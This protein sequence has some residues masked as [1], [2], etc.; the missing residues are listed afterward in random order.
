MKTYH[1]P[2]YVGREFRAC[3]PSSHSKG[4]ISVEWNPTFVLC[5]NT[6]YVLFFWMKRCSHSAYFFFLKIEQKECYLMFSHISQTFQYLKNKQNILKLLSVLHYNHYPI[7][8]IQNMICTFCLWRYLL[9]SEICWLQEETGGSIWTAIW[10]RC[11]VKARLDCAYL[12]NQPDT[13][14]TPCFSRQ[15]RTRTLYSLCSG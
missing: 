8:P 10:S 12:G 13:G 3:S 11:M 14:R 7:N 5:A 1:R 9:I 6:R 4:L 15:T 2:T